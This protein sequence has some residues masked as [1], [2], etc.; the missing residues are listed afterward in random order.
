MNQQVFL[1]QVSAAGLLLTISGLFYSR[2]FA[3]PGWIPPVLGALLLACAAAVALART[4]MGRVPRTIALV[5]L[6]LI[7]VALTVI[8][9]GTSFGGLG[10]IGSALVGSTVDGWR[11]TLAQTLPINTVAVEAVGFITVAAWITGMTTGVLLARSHQSA[12][13]TI[14]AI[15]FAALSLPLAAPNGVVTY[16]LIAALVAGALL[17]ALVRAVPQS[18]FK[19]TTRPAAVTEFVGERMLTERLT[20]GVI[21]LVALALLAPLAALFIPALRDEPFDPRQLR[22]EEVVTAT[23]VNP[24][25]E[26]KALRENDAPAFRLT[27][28]AA[29][30]PVFFDRVGL[31]SLENYDGVNWTTSSTY[32][33]TST[34]VE[35]SFDRDVP[36]VPVRQEIEL[37]DATA[38]PWL[39]AGQPVSR[40]EDDDIWFDPDSG[41]LLNRS[42][43]AERTYAIV[44]QVSAPNADQLQ[45]ASTD[46]S[47]L[48]FLELPTIS[49]DSPITELATGIEGS[50][51]FERLESLEAIL[52]DQLTLVTD[53]RSGTAVGRVEEFLVDG[54]GYRDQFVS[55]FAIA[56]RQQGFPARVTV[57]YRVAQEAEDSTLVFLDTVTSQHYDAWPEVLFEGI[58]WVAFD[59][60]PPTSGEARADADDAT[61]IPEGQPA[62][63]GPT[64]SPDDPAEDDEVDD[65]ELP[66]STTLRLLVVSG[67]FFLFFPLMLLL[68]VVIA[69]VLR[70]R[71]RQNLENPTD[72]LLAGWQESKDRLLEAG[73]E[74]RPD[75]TVKEI[76]TVSRRE[77]GVHASSSLSALAPYITTT[78]YSDHAPSSSAADAV[79]HEVLLFDE[80]LSD[81][82]TRTQN[83]KARVDP[84]PLL[85]RV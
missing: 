29:P 81:S 31:V 60:V 3:G 57:G 21:P 24:L 62:R 48:R 80:Q 45:A 7:F 22:E 19:G 2:V 51:D 38:S 1:G 65:E 4:G 37:L 64:P 30:S 76:V 72:R 56:A 66:A 46:A 74:I 33:A 10:D 9:P 41:T 50:T 73:I 40:I 42:N 85:E 59:P 61:P 82:R 43:A 20:S 71:Y 36:V 28:P 84:R 83:L 14:P 67:L 35:I 25:A 77:L 52:S 55:A 39:P 34:D 75:M 70:R 27:L 15:L 53:E 23:A 69:K 44:S 26:L 11:N 79:W 16:L 68:V 18:R 32:A 13:A 78:I 47:D 8:L 17:L 5:A 58:G 63:Q 6:G 12:S 54:E 49:P